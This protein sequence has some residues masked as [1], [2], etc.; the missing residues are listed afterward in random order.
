MRTPDEDGGT[1]PTLEGALDADRALVYGIGGGGDVVGAIPTARL[2][3]DH[4]VETILGG[5]PWERPVVDPTPGPYPLDRIEGIERV[6]ETVGLATGDSGTADGVILAETRVA[7][8]VDETV[9]LV[10]ISA[11]PATVAEGLQTAREALDLDLVVGVDAGGDA[12]ARGGEPGIRSP[13]ADAIAVAALDLADV[14]SMIGVYGWG[15]D[16]ELTPDELDSALAEVASR[17]GLLGAWGLTPRVCRELDELFEIVP[18]EASRLPVDAA[19]GGLGDREIRDGT[20][21]LRLT[22]ASTVTFYCGTEAVAA[23]SDPARRVRETSDLEAAHDALREAGYV[24]ELAIER[25]DVE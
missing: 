3:E 8:H 11:G 2:L 23:V 13:I 7:A 22:A 1:D 24:T 14:P 15:S 25:G 9:A 20:R 21:S 5:V 12:L 6:S 4:G 19:R 16:G 17:D 10:D 18:T